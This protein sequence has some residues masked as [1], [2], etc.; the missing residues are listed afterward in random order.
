MPADE[1]QSRFPSAVVRTSDHQ[2]ADPSGSE[3][4]A[5]GGPKEVA[6]VSLRLSY[7]VGSSRSFLPEGVAE[8]FSGK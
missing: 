3:A 6:V 2:G 7:P 1:N 5:C 4:G 8:D